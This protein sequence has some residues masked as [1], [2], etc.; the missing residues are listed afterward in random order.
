M[1]SPRYTTTGLPP[2]ASHGHTAFL[3]HFHRLAASGAMSYKSLLPGT[4][5]A[6]KVPAPTID[7][8]PSP[9]QGDKVLYGPSASKYA[10]DAFWP[11]QYVAVPH[12]EYL[13]G[14]GMPV[15]RYDP[16]RPQDTTM[17]PVPATSL[18]ATL[19][20]NAARLAYGV[21]PGG[22]RQV[23]AIPRQLQRW[24]GRNSLGTDNG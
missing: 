15:Q 18:R 9:D 8:V 4:G 23:K 22:Q 24:L 19:Q 17:I 14:A 11:N 12:P 7:T 5:P 20:A 6:H 10:P 3:P 13:P 1:P 21:N 2:E 16:T